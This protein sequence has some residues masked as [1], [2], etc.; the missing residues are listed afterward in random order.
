[1]YF[2][3]ATLGGVLIEAK[4]LINGISIVQ[5]DRLERVDY[6]HIELDTHDVILAEGAASETFVD[7]HSRGMF[8]NAH[9]YY[10]LHPDEVAPAVAYYHAPRLEQ[11]FVVEAVRRRIAMRAGLEPVVQV[12]DPGGMRGFV[13][14]ASTECIA[15]W[16]QST[17]H[18]DAPVCLD[19]FAGGRLIG[20]VL[21]NNYRADLEQA[22]IGTGFH[23]F[24]FAP[25]GGPSLENLEVR[26][27]LDGTLLTFSN[28]VAARWTRSPLGFPRQQKSHVNVKV[29]RRAKSGLLHHEPLT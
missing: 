8:H 13:D 23:S 24:A 20:Q 27:S 14:V 16:A 4:D 18:P 19:I 7:D 15:G 22:G 26:R 3:N 11:G 21:A 17:L 29:Y 5:A 2:E 6:L 1:M 25:P 12:S 10:A 9:E 28:N